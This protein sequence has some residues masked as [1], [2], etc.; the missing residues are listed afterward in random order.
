[1]SPLP[2]GVS[3]ATAGKTNA[4]IKRKCFMHAAYARA[5]TGQTRTTA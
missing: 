3:A 1:V 5:M 2:L 4:N